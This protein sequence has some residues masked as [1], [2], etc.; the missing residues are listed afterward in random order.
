MNPQETP[1]VASRLSPRQE[2]V[3]R[4]IANGKLL[5]E[6]SCELGISFKTAERHRTALYRKLKV[7]SAFEATRWAV[8]AGIGGGSATGE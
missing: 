5:K 6:I 3:L 8:A 7:Q 2:A 1:T 4:G